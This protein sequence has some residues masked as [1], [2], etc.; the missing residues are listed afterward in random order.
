MASDDDSL[1]INFRQFLGEEEKPAAHGYAEVVIKAL[2]SAALPFGI[3]SA[4]TGVLGEFAQQAYKARVADLFVA[5]ANAIKSVADR[6]PDPT[7]YGGEE[8]LSLCIEAVDQ[9]R[10]NRHREK[11]KLLANG[12]ANSGTTPFVDDQEKESYFRVLRDLTLGDLAVLD[13]VAPKLLAEG[14]RKS[15]PVVKGPKPPKDST[16]ARLE[17]L[18]LVK[19]SITLIPPA[20]ASS[21]NQEIAK[22]FDSQT[23]S[24]FSISEFGLKFLEFLSI[25]S[26]NES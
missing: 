15:Q 8:F 7:F 25:D 17:G 10:T 1:Q 12:L 16:F 3:G 19:R 9:Q 13:S 5:L 26:A 21:R 11:R 4:I 22:V 6:I 24:S 14:L 20:N 23:V 2:V 18:G